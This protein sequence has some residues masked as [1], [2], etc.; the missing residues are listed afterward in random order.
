M[1]HLVGWLTAPWTTGGSWAKADI[2]DQP[3]MSYL[4]FGKMPDTSEHSHRLPKTPSGDSQGL[5]R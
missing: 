1:C 3:E 2:Q 4:H 5:A